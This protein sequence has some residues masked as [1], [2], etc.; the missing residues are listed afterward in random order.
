MTLRDWGVREALLAANL[1]LSDLRIDVRI[2]V[3]GRVSVDEL[4]QANTLALDALGD[5][6]TIGLEQRDARAAQILDK[7]TATEPVERAHK[8]DIGINELFAAL[9]LSTF[10]ADA[11]RD[12][13]PAFP[14]DIAWRWKG[15]SGDGSYP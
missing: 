14:D 11:I 7:M 8:A 10:A 1:R 13:L 3:A 5:G 12:G 9:D 6:D 2:D 4:L 15:E